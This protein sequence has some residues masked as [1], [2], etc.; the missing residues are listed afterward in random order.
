VP[1][2]IP[3]RL[4]AADWRLMRALWASSACEGRATARQVLDALEPGTEWAYTTVKTML[5]RLVEKRHVTRSK[6]GL[7]AHYRARLSREDAERREVKALSEGVFGGRRAPLVHYLVESERLSE[8][9]RAELRRL[10]AQAGID[11][12]AGGDTQGGATR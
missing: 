12:E 5:D 7:A 6:R 10:L 4:S 11:T 8:R 9:D 3:I 2:L 1:P